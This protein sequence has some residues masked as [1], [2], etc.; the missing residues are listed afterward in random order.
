V[1]EPASPQ[2]WG[3]EHSIDLGAVEGAVEGPETAQVREPSP[4]RRYVYIH[5]IALAYTAIAIALAAAVVTV[6]KWSPL[7]RPVAEAAVLSFLEAVREGDVEG[8]LAHTDQA[9]ILDPDGAESS[10][11]DPEGADLGESPWETV[12]IEYL[13]PEALDPRWE[14]V[15]VAQVAFRA[16]G[17]EGRF[18]AQVYAEIEAHDGTRLGH[19]YQ[20]AVERGKAVLER[21]IP[22]VEAWASMDYLD[23]NGVELE[24]DPEVGFANIYLLP[25][26]YVFYPDLPPTVEITESAEMLV[27]GDL[28]LTLGQDTPDVWLPSPWPEVTQ[29]GEDAVNAALQAHYDDCAIG[30]VSDGC[31]FEFPEDPERELALAPGAVW[32]VTAYPTVEAEQL[33]YE[34]GLG[35]LLQTAVPGEAQVQVEITEDGATRTALVSCPIWVDGLYA[36]LHDDGGA[37]VNDESNQAENHCRAIVEVG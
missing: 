1:S 8:A 12:R 24:M 18:V 11:I 4:P 35:Y 2:P 7:H 17:R 34:F 13:V 9:D 36:E 26:F 20:V 23:I 6:V 27:L 16:S 5:N 25:G 28:F 14:I 37:S 31:A 10:D 29:E 33:W 22:Q 32:E 3:R 30:A 21:P 19:R 15:T